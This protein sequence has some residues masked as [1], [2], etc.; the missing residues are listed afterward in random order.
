MEVFGSVDLCVGMEKPG[1]AMCREQV[2]E[3]L[4]APQLLNSPSLVALE[5]CLLFLSPVYSCT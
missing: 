2:L 1:S 3:P 4:L 5:D